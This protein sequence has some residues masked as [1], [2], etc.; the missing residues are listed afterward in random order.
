MEN[1]KHFLSFLIALWIYITYLIVRYSN[2]VKAYI[3]DVL[4]G[5]G[6]V[7]FYILVQDMEKQGKPF[8]ILYPYI[9]IFLLIY[10]VFSVFYIVKYYS[11]KSQLTSSE[12]MLQSEKRKSEYEIQKKEKQYENTIEDL[13]KENKDL[14]SKLS[15]VNSAHNKEFDRLHSEY[16][17]ELIYLKELNH[18]LQ[19]EIAKKDHE[20]IRSFRSSSW[21]DLL[22]KHGEEKFSPSQEE[23]DMIHYPPLNINHV[24]FAKNS[25]RFHSVFWCYTLDTSSKTY[26]TSV[27]DARK[28]DLTP[29]SKCI[30]P[31]TYMDI[32]REINT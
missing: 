18:D 9:I 27:K 31:E 16:S 15:V 28:M 32:F 23:I 22:T 4:I 26:L 20:L 13:K 5:G 6:M 2:S 19:T 7:I 21:G 12:A 30:D 1:F 10:L 17:S 14:R 29:C 8:S 11:T 24:Y 25:K 3:I